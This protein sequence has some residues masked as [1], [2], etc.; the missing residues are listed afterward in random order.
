MCIKTHKHVH[1]ISKGGGSYLGRSGPKPK[2]V[3]FTRKSGP[4]LLY[5]ME[6]LAQGGVFRPQDHPLVTGLDSIRVYFHT[7]TSTCIRSYNF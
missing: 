1:K 4:F 6:L 3:I 5:A 7:H 2:G